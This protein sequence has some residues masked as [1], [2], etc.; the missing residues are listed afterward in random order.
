VN[1]H[2]L[3]STTAPAIQLSRRL[4]RVRPGPFADASPVSW[5]DD[6]RPPAPDPNALWDG[7]TWRV[8]STAENVADLE[9]VRPCPGVAPGAARRHDDAPPIPW[10][11]LD[12]RLLGI[13][14]RRGRVGDRWIW[15]A[16]R[17]AQQTMFDVR[18]Q[19]ARA[20]DVTRN[21]LREPA[22]LRD[23]ALG[24]TPRELRLVVGVLCSYE[25]GFGGLYD[26]QSTIAADLNL[27]SERTLRNLLHGTSWKRADG[28]RV[29]R[30]G[31]IERGFIEAIQ[32]FKAGRADGRPSDHDWLLLRIGPTI[33]RA[34]AWTTLAKSWTP[35]APRG[36]GWSRRVARAMA[37]GLRSRAS[38][39]RFTTA[40]RA[41]AARTR[42]SSAAPE[43][44]TP[45]SSS[46][47]PEN[48]TPAAAAAPPENRT[49]LPI[50][51][52]VDLDL[53]S[54]TLDSIRRT[55]A[56]PKVT[57]DERAAA[58]AECERL[59]EEHP[60]VLGLSAADE[61]ALARAESP[62]TT[63]SPPPE[64][65]DSTG[66]NWAESPA[67]NPASQGPTS[68]A[69][70]EGVGGSR[71]TLSPA[72]GH[73]LDPPLARRDEEP[74]LTRREP[75]ARR[76]QPSRAGRSGA[77][78]PNA[79][80]LRGLDLA[81]SGGTR[82]ASP[83]VTNRAHDAP[84]CPDGRAGQASEPV[85][86]AVDRDAVARRLAAR[87]GAAADAAAT[88]TATQDP[89]LAACLLDFARAWALDD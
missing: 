32:T 40:G 57:A 88:A 63:P 26:C 46:S 68:W 37:A 10:R 59:R 77:V 86:N 48:R 70:W 30:P 36:T 45:P 20:M 39:E 80:D 22:W 8:C 82:G 5:D 74:P 23:E 60:E 41:W 6:E 72:H 76:F 35:R 17:S 7:T 3:S 62:R 84:R 69:P 66:L 19:T 71:G 43:N 4:A 14:Q 54:R 67:D 42:P 15:A 12:A 83:P 49:M 79:A 58:V 44:R 33:E 47:A 89:Q 85:S 55:Q 9:R 29:R 2:H 65:V 81:S 21:D 73:P 16:G 52:L 1:E 56:G 28:T 87:G 11:L 27:G 78:R 31:L 25:T 75:L 38:R 64:P 61:R 24:L 34:A 53:V 51:D 50:G 18:Q 13:E